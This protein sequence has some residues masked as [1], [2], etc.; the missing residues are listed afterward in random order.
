MDDR[1][2][3]YGI[4]YAPEI[5]GVGRYTGEIG[6]HL[7]SLGC[8]VHVVTA[9]PHYPGW[10]VKAPYSAAR[11]ITEQVAGATVHRCPI[12]LHK[13]MSGVYRL[14]APFSFALSSAPVALFHAF[15][16]RP[17]VVLA[18]E[19]TLFTA[20]M[21]LAVAKFAGAK[22]VLHVQDLEIDAAFAM[23]HLGGGTLGTIARALEQVVLRRFDRV[24]TI[25][26]RMVEKLAKKGVRPERITLVR[27]WVDLSLVKPAKKSLGYRQ[28]LGLG[29]TDFIALYSGNIGAKQ[30]VRLLVEVARQLASEPRLVIVVAGEGPMRSELETAAQSLPNLRIFDFQPEARFGEFLSIA[31]LHVL[32]QEREAADLMLP[33]KLGGLLASGRPVIVTAEAG[34]ELGEFLDG[35]C[36]LT[37]PGDAGALANAILAASQTLPCA[38]REAQRLQLAGTLSKDLG[39]QRFTYAVLFLQA[40]TPAAESVR[41]S[42]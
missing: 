27:N 21:A 2:L 40:G 28:E 10:R 7:A 1:V 23:G 31:D 18:I 8:D 33:S 12:Y 29:A 22:S 5:A 11:W 6:G 16:H 20:P 39:I 17:D 42:A 13:K 4:N 15:R 37:A 35:S 25:S 32:P 24:I 36:V 34:T 14:L 30:G 41:Q 38:K 9:P 19:P 3:I 26:S